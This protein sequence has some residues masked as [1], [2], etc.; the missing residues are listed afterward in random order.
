MGTTHGMGTACKYFNR[1]NT[2]A[3]KCCVWFDAC[4]VVFIALTYI[5]MLTFHLYEC[6]PARLCISLPNVS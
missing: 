2:T 6:M 4:F 5:A 1:L 3:Q